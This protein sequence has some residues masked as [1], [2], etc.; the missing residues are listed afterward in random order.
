MMK[1]TDILCSL[2]VMLESRLEEMETMGVEHD[3]DRG[4]QTAY[5]L[6][7]DFLNP[8]SVTETMTFVP[9]TAE[10]EKNHPA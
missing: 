9:T 1:K 10:H 5:R 7:L 8:K 4:R 6:T 3:F 2:I